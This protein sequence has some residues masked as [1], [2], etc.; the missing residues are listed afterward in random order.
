MDLLK[1]PSGAPLCV[2]VMS[3]HWSAETKWKNIVES[4]TIGIPIA[5]YKAR[6]KSWISPKIDKGRSK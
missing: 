3:G 2:A 6:P 4:T 5:W 1:R